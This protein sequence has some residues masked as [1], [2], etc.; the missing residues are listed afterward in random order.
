MGDIC[1]IFIETMLSG[2]HVL[3]VN[4]SVDLNPNKLEVNDEFEMNYIDKLKINNL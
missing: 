4:L 1:M 3:F 2:L